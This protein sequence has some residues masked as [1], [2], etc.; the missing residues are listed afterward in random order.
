MIQHAEGP[1]AIAD[2]FAKRLQRSRDKLAALQGELER[3]LDDPG[4]NN[5]TKA[6]KLAR[7][8]W[9]L[10]TSRSNT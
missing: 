4:C 9:A 6:T 1:P 10:D 7:L 8:K 5:A 2:E 3:Y